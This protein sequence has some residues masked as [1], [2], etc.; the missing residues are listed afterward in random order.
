MNQHK[1]S[2]D[3]QL[4]KEF[5]EKTLKQF[6]NYKS[7]AEK[8]ISQV[9]SDENLNKQIDNESNSIAIIIKHLEGNM[10][11]RWTDVYTTDGEKESRKR[12]TEFDRTFNPTRKELMDLWEHGWKI[13]FD[14]F[15]TFTPDKLLTTIYIRKEP[16][17]IMDAILRQVAHYAN[18]VGQIMFLAKHLEYDHWKH[19]TL[20]RDAEVFDTKEISKN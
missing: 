7:W 5:L 12:P 4:G 2:L 19:V 17:T 3:N 13:L 6:K 10:Q 16:H 9:T 8:A 11:S 1:E 14:T 15:D 20:P 18:H